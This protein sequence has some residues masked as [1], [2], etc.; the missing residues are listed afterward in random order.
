MVMLTPLLAYAGNNNPDE[1]IFRERYPWKHELRIGY[2]GAP[3]LD[4]GVHHSSGGYYIYDVDSPDYNTLINIYGEK[5]GSEY[6]TGVFSA[7]YSFHFR[8]W[9][10]LVANAAINGMW[11]H[12]YDPA[13]NTEFDCRRG[14][15]VQITPAARFQWVNSKYVRLYTTVGVGLY[16]SVYGGQWKFFPAAYTTPIGI[17]VG[18][19]VFFYAETSLSTAS[20]GGNFGIGYRF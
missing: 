16:T 5:N 14:V 4:T 12:K 19:Q 7:E 1:D 6:V 13:S 20:L 11:G 17:S 2:G 3:A 8:R 18:R 9:F 10:S 15:S